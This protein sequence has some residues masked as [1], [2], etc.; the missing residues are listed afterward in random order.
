MDIQNGTAAGPSRGL[1]DVLFGT[2]GAEKDDAEG[3]GFKPLMELIKALKENGEKENGNRTDEEI[4]SGKNVAEGQV[5]GMLGMF[6][7]A[8]QQTQVNPE[9]IMQ[10]GSVKDSAPKATG[11]ALQLKSTEV[12]MLMQEKGM[13]KLTAEEEKLLGEVNARLATA[14]ALAANKGKANG[15]E[16]AEGV[17]PEMEVAPAVLANVPKEQQS[18]KSEQ[19]SKVLGDKAILQ[20]GAPAPFLSTEAYLQ[21][22]QGKPA[23]KEVSKGENERVAVASPLVAGSVEDKNSSE[24]PQN[25]SKDLFSKG[26]MPKLDKSA[27]G[28]KHL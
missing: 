4:S 12:N 17:V 19:E 3:A 24:K 20:Q 1:L 7:F 9:A 10:D 16:S 21:L 28:K 18:A 27:S 8:P 26:Q 2:K 11:D 6:P 13:P 15:G 22:H 5:V 23:P 14:V 25:Q